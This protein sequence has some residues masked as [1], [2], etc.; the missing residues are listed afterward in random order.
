MEDL[1]FEASEDTVDVPGRY[2]QPGTF[3]IAV[4]EQK[5]KIKLRGDPLQT[6]DWTKLD[7]GY[8]EVQW[9]PSLS[10]DNPRQLLY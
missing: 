9:P 6:N 2:V 8:R 5:V 1:A 3:T 7:E 4:G 10:C